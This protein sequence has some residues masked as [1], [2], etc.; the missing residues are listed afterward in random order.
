MRIPELAHNLWW[1]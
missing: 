1:A